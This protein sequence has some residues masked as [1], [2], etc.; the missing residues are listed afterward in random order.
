[1]VKFTDGPAAGV[2]LM[3]KRAPVLLRVVHSPSGEWDALD[4]LTDI[5]AANETITVYRRDGDA[6]P[7]HLNFGG[8]KRGRASGF[9]QMATYRVMP[10]QPE[11]EHTRTNTA[12]QKW[13]SETV[14][15]Q[16]PDE[17]SAP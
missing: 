2:T 11:A 9:Y 12:W 16:Q 8:G 7:V 17:V 14:W 1:M 4:Q 3:L 6:L 13:A 5:P 10:A 15:D